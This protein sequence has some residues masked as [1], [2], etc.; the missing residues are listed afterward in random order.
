VTA[1]SLSQVTK[2]YGEK[3]VLD[4]ESLKIEKGAIYALLGPNGAGKTTLLKILGFLDYP[5]AGNIYFQ[6]TPVT[7]SQGFL[8]PLRRKVVMV[9]QRPI[10]FTTTVY[11]NLE[12]GLKIRKIPKKKRDRIIAES[13]DLVGMNHMIHAQAHTLSGGETQ[14]VALARAVALSPGVILCD[15]P[16]SS[17][18]LENQVTIIN[19]LRQINKEKK[20]TLV[21]TSHDKLQAASLAHHTLFLDQGR[22]AAAAYENLFTGVLTAKESGLSLCV[23]QNSL[24]LSISSDKTGKVRLLIDPEKIYI[25]QDKEAGNGENHFKGTVTQVAQEKGKIRMVVKSGVY[26]TLLLSLEKYSEVRPMVGETVHIAIAP[27]AV[28]II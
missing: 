1:Y 17:V 25:I 3:T 22:L 28:K 23:I 5:T 4:I 14:R 9:N 18:D 6:S 20:I 2:V 21:F 7:F 10:L 12:F 11:K 24:T 27:D 16:T 26:I 15:E 19:L 8:Q 13:L